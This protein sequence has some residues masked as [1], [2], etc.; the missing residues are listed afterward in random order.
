MDIPYNSLKGILHVT[1]PSGKK[2]LT[3]S[4]LPLSSQETQPTQV[5]YQS[6]TLL[7]LFHSVRRV[8]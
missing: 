2:S 5:T 8:T 4:E 6:P 3:R 7:D 1:W